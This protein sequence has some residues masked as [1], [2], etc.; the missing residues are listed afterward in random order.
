MRHKTK[1]NKTRDSRP[2]SG[3]INSIKHAWVDNTIGKEETIQLENRRAVDSEVQTGGDDE[4][5]RPC[6]QKP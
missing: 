3:Q 1:Q 4:K 5:E 6:N 2:D